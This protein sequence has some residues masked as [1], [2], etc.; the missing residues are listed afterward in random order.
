MI[1]INIPRA[2]ITQSANIL[3]GKNKASSIINGMDNKIE[4][5]TI[6]LILSKTNSFGFE[7]YTQT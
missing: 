2:K 6:D 3:E 1:L 4:F 5:K 7:E